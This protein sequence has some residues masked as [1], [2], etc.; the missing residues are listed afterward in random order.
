LRTRALPALSVAVFAVAAA[1]CGAELAPEELVA[2]PIERSFAPAAGDPETDVPPQ[3]SLPPQRETEAPPAPPVEE[4]PSDE[5]LPDAEDGTV[6]DAGEAEGSGA[7]AAAPPAD[8]APPAKQPAQPTGPS[9]GQIAA[10][11][12]AST[13]A[14]VASD[15]RTLDV[16]GD[17]IRDVAVGIRT[18]EGQVELILGTW[19]GDAVRESGRVAH[20][21]ST[22]LGA[23][24]VGDL[25]GDGRLELLLPYADRP[26]VGVLVASVTTRG[27]VATPSGCPVPAPTEKQLDFGSGADAVVLACH[28]RDARGRDGLVW[29]DG[30]FAGALA[31]GGKA[32]TSDSG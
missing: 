11:V 2:V 13:S 29:A 7:V 4:E 25:T 14:A 5:D 10:F 19:D 17:G 8:P 26:H 3:R 27:R 28:Q 12:R 1:G 32:R 30:V 24:A 16:T 22:G 23:L 18:L 9:D 15:H 20:P 6:E 21:R 31:A